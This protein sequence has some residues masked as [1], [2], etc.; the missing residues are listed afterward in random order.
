M[1]S[2]LLVGLVLETKET[3]CWVGAII[4]NCGID[5]IPIKM[6]ASSQPL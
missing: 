1:H 4:Q 2:I 3:D 6:S 5:L